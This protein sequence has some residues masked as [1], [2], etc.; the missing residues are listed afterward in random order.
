MAA[1][2]DQAARNL[3]REGVADGS[4]GG[5]RDPDDVVAGARQMAEPERPLR[6]G[7]IQLDAVESLYLHD[8]MKS[9]D[10]VEGI[11]AFLEKRPPKYEAP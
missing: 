5:G 4:L 9:R 8:L 11:R 2:E 1:I 6:P 7:C 10:A 3:D